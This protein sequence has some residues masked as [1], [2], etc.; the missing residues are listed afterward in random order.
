MRI[1]VVTRHPKSDES[2]CE[3]CVHRRS[4]DRH[5]MFSSNYFPDRVT[6]AHFV[7]SRECESKS[8]I[9]TETKDISMKAEGFVRLRSTGLYT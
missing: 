4:R 6:F 5:P 2:L 9:Y 1:Y 8:S 3:F 7:L